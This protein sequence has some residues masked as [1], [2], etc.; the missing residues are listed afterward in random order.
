[1]AELQLPKLTTRVR[2]PSLA[3]RCLSRENAAFSLFN[4]LFQ[5][6]SDCFIVQR[7]VRK[8]NQITKKITQKSHE[9]SHEIVLKMRL[10]FVAV[11]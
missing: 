2:F 7:I 5:A 9:K 6:I 8:S 1:M 10:L 4:R 11:I 3:P